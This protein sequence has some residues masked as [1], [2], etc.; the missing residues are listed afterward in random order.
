[1][2]LSNMLREPRRE[3]IETVVGFGAVVLALGLDYGFA[4]WLEDFPWGRIY[5]MAG[6][7]I[8]AKVDAV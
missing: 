8:L 2:A 5:A 4:L 3:I 1:M 7:A 6:R